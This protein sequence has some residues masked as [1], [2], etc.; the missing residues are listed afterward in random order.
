MEYGL[1]CRDNTGKI[2]LDTI[3]NITRNVYMSAQTAS[4]NN[5]GALDQLN[6]IKSGEFCV[7]INADFT[8]SAHTVSR[9]GDTISW[10]TWSYSGFITPATCIIFSFGY[11]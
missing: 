9:S 4:S 11:T 6:G 3:N 7:P 1:R 2:V 8:K 10:T 5:S